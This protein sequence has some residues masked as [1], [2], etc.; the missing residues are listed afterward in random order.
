MYR[1]LQRRISVI[2]SH[3]AQT[4]CLCRGRH[5]EVVDGST[6]TGLLGANEADAVNFLRASC[7]CDS[8]PFQKHKPQHPRASR[9]INALKPSPILDFGNFS[10][11]GA[12][13]FSSGSKC[14]GRVRPVRARTVPKRITLPSFQL[15][16][17][18]GLDQKLHPADA[19]SRSDGKRQVDVNHVGKSEAAVAEPE[20]KAGVGQ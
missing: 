6:E 11:W 2:R 17:A 14:T 18:L 10:L 4:Q 20:A 3:A 15:E 12:L 13:W 16:T 7:A 8:E 5:D 9:S 1:W 19:I